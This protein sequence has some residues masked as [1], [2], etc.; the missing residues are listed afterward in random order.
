MAFNAWSAS[1]ALTYVLEGLHGAD[2]YDLAILDRGPFDALAWF[3]LLSSEGGISVDDRN[4]VQEFLQIE[5]WRGVID[6]VFLF[7][8]D[9]ETAMERENRDKLIEERGKAMNPEFLERLNNAY[10]TVEEKFST[11]F[12]RF[13]KIDTGSAAQTTAKS[14]AS[15]VAAE[16]LTIFEDDLAQLGQ[17]S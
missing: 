4:R 11:G 7:R 15:E 2:R 13:K 8:T 9:P 1:Y 16:I 6:Q 3:E 17:G 5:H 12:A 14:T 10:D